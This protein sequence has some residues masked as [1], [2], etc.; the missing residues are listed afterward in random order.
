M[1]LRNRVLFA[2]G[3]LLL[4]GLLPGPDANGGPFLGYLQVRSWLLDARRSPLRE[5]TT[6]GQLPRLVVDLRQ[7][8]PATDGAP[9]AALEQLAREW[10]AARTAEGAPTTV[11]T[12]L[13]PLLLAVRI[14]S[15]GVRAGMPLPGAREAGLERALPSRL[16]LLPAAIAIVVAVLLQ[17]VLLALL[18]AGLA[19]SLTFAVTQIHPAMG[20][21]IPLETVAHFFHDCLW[22]RAL[23][24]DFYLRI[25]VFVLMLFATVAITTA[26]GGF[27]GLVELLQRRVRGPVGAQLCTFATGCVLMFDDYTN[28]MV[29]GTAMRPLCDAMRV[30]RA[31]LAFLVDSTAAPIAGISLFS[32]WVAYETSQY[33]APLALVTRADGTPYR[34]DDAIA[35]FVQCMPYRFYCLFA[36]ALV[37]LVIV[38]RRDFGPMLAAE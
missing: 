2:L 3:L 19:G 12:T 34:S 5:W 33:R 10:A 21:R 28:C 38:M 15:A 17:R 25:T 35:V 30:S 20:A 9:A 37:V 8:P 36:L 16:S 32:T 27:A 29:G 26:N 7:S 18:L 31:K 6:D 1:R 13:P 24:E 4:F 11:S 14:G 23:G 22:S